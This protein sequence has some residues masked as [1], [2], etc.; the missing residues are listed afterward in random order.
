MIK[1]VIFDY[2]QVLYR[3]V[4]FRQKPLFDLALQLRNKGVKTAILSN[5]VQPLVFL[6][7]ILG[8]I[9]NFSPVIFCTDIGRRKPDPAPY[10]HILEKLYLKP[11][12]C[13]YVDNREENLKTASNMGM[14]VVLAKNTSITVAEIRRKLKA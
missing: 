13:M 3:Y 9:G 8:T 5:R 11:E 6:A 10:R 7:K 14:Q 4:I 1:A 2:D 12:E